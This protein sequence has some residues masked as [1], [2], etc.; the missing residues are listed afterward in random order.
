MPAERPGETLA[1]Y[2][3]E[4]ILGVRVC[5]Y[6][7]GGNSQPDGIIHRDGGVPLEVVSD[8]YKKDLQLMRALDKMQRRATIAGLQHG[9]ELWILPEA[10]PLKDL[11]WLAELCRAKEDPNRRDLIPP[12]S[13][14]YSRLEIDPD[15]APGEIVFTPAWFS[16]GPIPGPGD[17]AK[18]VGEILSRE[19]YADVPRKLAAYGGTERHAFVIGD[20]SNNPI[21]G[22][23]MGLDPA[24]LD[25]EPDPN[26]PAEVTHLWVGARHH[27]QTVAQWTRG[28]GWSGH[29]W[30][31]DHPK[32][33]IESWDDPECVEH[34]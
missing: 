8:P 12:I 5:R 34:R 33:V 10:P 22:R 17:I 26:V 28:I 20:Q 25:E 18:A 1:R 19:A 31:W 29:E 23:L 3:V 13:D 21:F 6:D 30:E 15:L 27:P 4:Q 24:A 32:V 11:T 9:Y 14:W 16:E 7:R 2:A